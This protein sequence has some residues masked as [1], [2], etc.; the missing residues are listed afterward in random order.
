M[1][2]H[3]RQT[4]HTL[5]GEARLIEE[6]WKLLSSASRE[7]FGAPCTF[8]AEEL[9]QRV[10]EVAHDEEFPNGVSGF[11]KVLLKSPS[12]VTLHGAGVSL[13]CGYAHRSIEPTTITLDYTTPLSNYPTSA[14][15]AVEAL[16]TPFARQRGA[17]LAVSVGNEGL[18]GGCD[19]TTLFA[20]Q[21]HTLFRSQYQSVE[22]DLV[23]RVAQGM[24]LSLSR[25]PLTREHLHSADEL[26]YIDHRGV[27]SIRSCDNTPYMSIIAEQIAERIEAIFSANGER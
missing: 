24:G 26:F 22:G 4:V 9:R 23:A 27:S 20:L 17:D 5:R 13:Y 1:E 18:V 14:H 16:A 25:E 3:I 6:H 19:G 7:I 15:Y 10:E 21:A 12:E 11:V 8:S 2:L